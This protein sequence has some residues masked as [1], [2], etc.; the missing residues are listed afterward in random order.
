MKR[1]NLGQI[2][3]GVYRKVISIN[4]AVLWK[5]KEISLSKQA[6]DKFTADLKR[7]EF[8]DKGK[9][10]I[11]TAP[12][13]RVREAWTYKTMHQEPQYYI[14]ITV[15][16]KFTGADYLSYKAG[17]P[18]VKWNEDEYHRKEDE[19]VKINQEVQGRLV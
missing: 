2:K 5:T 19:R 6:V 15:F 8:E 14:P 11:W 12:L 17:I 4:Q 13:N 18:R 10:A 1:I 9:R 3:N 7:I 16:D